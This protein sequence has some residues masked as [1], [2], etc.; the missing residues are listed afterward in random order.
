MTLGSTEEVT[1]CLVHMWV[2][3]DFCQIDLCAALSPGF[4][5]DLGDRFEDVGP[6]IEEA[7]GAG[8][9]QVQASLRRQSS[10]GG[11]SSAPP[12]GILSQARDEDGGWTLRALPIPWV[13]MTSQELRG[14]WEGSNL[15]SPPLQQTILCIF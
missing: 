6:G 2:I 9:A 8:K 11:R 10:M 1:F 13:E 12:S 7:L 15:P 3:L 4:S 14:W 5:H